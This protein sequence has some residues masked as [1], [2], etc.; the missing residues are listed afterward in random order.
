MELSEDG[1]KI[2]VSNIPFAHIPR[3]IKKM[4]KPN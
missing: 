4:I 2:R 1:E 3:E